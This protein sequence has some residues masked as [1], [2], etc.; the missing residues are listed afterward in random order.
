METYGELIQARRQL[1]DLL[2]KRY[3]R[4]LQHSKGYFYAHA[5]KG[6]K[7]L[8]HLLKGNAPRT[9]VRYLRLSSGTTTTFPNK[10]AGEFR[11]YYHSLYNIHVT[12]GNDDSDA[13][14]A[15]TRDYLQESITRTISSD[16]AERWTPSFLWRSSW[17]P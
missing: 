6:C 3:L 2:T 10:I 17:R 11:K 7:Y 12:D 15:R 9:Q 4:S 14:D 5:N 8:A 16:T 1:K 13:E